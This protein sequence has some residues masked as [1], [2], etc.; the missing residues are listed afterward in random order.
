MAA[1]SLAISTCRDG[2]FDIRYY[3]Q[4]QGAGAPR[5]F[6]SSATSAYRYWPMDGFVYNRNLY[7]ALYQVVTKPGRGPFNFKLLGVTLA[8]IANPSDD[9]RLWQIKYLDLASDGVVFPGVAAIVSPPWVYLF[10]VLADD[11][12]G[13]HPMILTRLALE[14]L[15]NHPSAIEYLATNGSWK[16]G[17]NW[18]DARVVIDRGHTE[19]S[20]RYHPDM[21]KW[22]AVQQKPG[23]N[24]GI[25][26]RTADH[27]EGPWS[28]F[29]SW[30][31][32]PERPP[33]TDTGTFCYAA[34]EHIEFA[35]VSDLSVTYVCNS[36]DFAKQ[37]ADMSLYRPQVARTPIQ[38]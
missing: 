24:E 36:F 17:L 6:F 32:M 21:R 10:A 9:P 3:V 22:I 34:K 37:V 38:R 30:F 1:N 18:R 4:R 35:S 12:H 29:Q 31:A 15:D 33:H 11:T 19:M 2:E 14:R 7:V 28:S 5:A 25:G 27:L 23:V 8:R 26:L 16:P 20:I 13:E